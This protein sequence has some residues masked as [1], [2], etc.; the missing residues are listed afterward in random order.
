MKLLVLVCVCKPCIVLLHY[1]SLICNMLYSPVVTSRRK[2]NFFEKE[3]KMA[4]DTLNFGQILQKN[5]KTKN[6]S[7]KM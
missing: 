7:K 2:Y 3:F 5:S 4:D 6:Y 1:I